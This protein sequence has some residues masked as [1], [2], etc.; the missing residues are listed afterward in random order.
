M[1][2]KKGKTYT[3]GRALADGTVRSTISHAFVNGAWNGMPAHSGNTGN[4]NRFN[5]RAGGKK[6][7]SSSAKETAKNTAATKGNTKAT[8][9]NTKAKKKEAEVIDWVEVR[10]ERLGRATDNVAK[11]ITD[12]VSKVFKKT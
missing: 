9:G 6:S 10:L 11:T 1:L 3:P 8:K 5:K 4:N 12:F 7:A 2:L